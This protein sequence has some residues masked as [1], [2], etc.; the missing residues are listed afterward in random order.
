[1]GT[2]ETNGKYADL[3]GVSDKKWKIYQPKRALRPVLEEEWKAFP[4]VGTPPLIR[5][6]PELQKSKEIDIASAAQK[7]LLETFAPASLIVNGKGEIL[8]IHGQTGKYLEPAPGR[9]N[10]NIFDMVRKGAQFEVQSGVHYALTQMKERQYPRLRIKTNH[11]YHPVN[12]TVKPFAPTKETKGLV[13]VTFEDVADREKRKP[14]LKAGKPSRDKDERLQEAE[15]ELLY[16]RET[17]QATVEE[18]QASNEELK[19]TNEEMQSTN[20]EL[21][22]TN[23]ELETSREEL[24][25]MNEELVTVNSELQGK[26]DQLS[27]AEA[28][29]KV[30]LENTEI[31]IIFLD[32]RLRIER[33]TSEAKKA[34]N[35]IPSDVGRPLHDI[36]SNLEYD[37]VEKD[38]EEVLESLQKKEI[39]I[40]TKDGEWYLMQIVPYRSAA[41]KI[42]GV[43]LT[44]TDITEIKRANGFESIVETVREPMVVLDG[45]FKVIFANKS[46]CR[47]FQVSKEETEERLIYKLGDGQWDIPELRKLLEEILPQNN[48][49][50]DF[51]VEHDFPGIGRKRMLLNARR[52]IGEIGDEGAKILLAIED[53]TGKESLN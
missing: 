33:F 6:G 23:E 32:R 28:D 13:M 50:E 31:G 34:F 53:V 24:Q 11:E 5:M 8:Y 46:F 36:R 10:W 38:A 15:R 4:W 41:N 18:L 51:R 44:F 19:S 26:I 1:L 16:T 52:I 48:K 27:L 49:F 20:E 39:E 42:E 25:S 43:V 37:D 30:L 2:A 7:T 12:L 17:L 35:L 21:Q 9:P 3:F 40:Q 29:M 47:T 22:S 45:G 14:I